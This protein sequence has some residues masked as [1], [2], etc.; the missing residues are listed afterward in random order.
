MS[1]RAIKT[2]DILLQ[3]CSCGA[4]RFL[5]LIQI[6]K[7]MLKEQLTSA[8]AGII[9]HH[10]RE[11]KGRLTEVSDLCSINRKE[12]NRR[13]LSKMKLHRLLRLVYALA[14]IMPYREF[15][16]MWKDILDEIRNYSDDYDFTLLDE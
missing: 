12:F 15:D 1:S 7:S 2:F 14:L 11:T 3:A 16:V 13:G 6:T 5:C 4:R 10:V 8:V 9:L